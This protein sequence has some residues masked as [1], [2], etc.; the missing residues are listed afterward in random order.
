[1]SFIWLAPNPAICYPHHD[2]LHRSVLPNPTSPVCSI[3][4]MSLSTFWK[5]S[6]ERFPKDPTVASSTASPIDSPKSLQK[7]ENSGKG[8]SRQK[9][10]G[11]VTIS[12]RGVAVLD[13]PKSK[14]GKPLSLLRCCQGG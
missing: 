9:L 11:Y 1:V 12:R 10:A 2:S 14:I 4:S 13:T 7:H 6:A 5:C 8:R 3:P